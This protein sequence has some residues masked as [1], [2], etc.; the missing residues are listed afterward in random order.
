MTI[1]SIISSLQTFNAAITGV[2]AAPQTMPGR[3]DADML[4]CAITLP[5]PATWAPA[6]LGGGR[7][8]QRTYVVRFYVAPASDEA[9]EVS[10]AFSAGFTLLEAVGV[11]YRAAHTIGAGII[12]VRGGDR[13]E[14]LGMLRTLPYSGQQ[15]FGFEFRVPILE[16]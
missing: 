1:G 12:V 13:L 8:E 9:S 11:A 7:K 10:Q 6:G 2:T 3:L 15:F 4:P 16:Q 14:D 5:G